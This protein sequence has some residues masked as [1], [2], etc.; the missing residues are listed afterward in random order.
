MYPEI[1]RNHA[2]DFEATLSAATLGKQG[3]GHVRNINLVCTTAE[4]SQDCLRGG[5]SIPV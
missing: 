4:S 5:T 1:L 2:H 3:A